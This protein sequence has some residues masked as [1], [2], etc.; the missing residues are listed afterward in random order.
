MS[1]ARATVA[2]L[3]ALTLLQALWGAWLAPLPGARW[4]ALKAVPL[5]ILVPGVARGQRRARQ[6]LALVTP[7]YFGEALVRAL[8]ESGR[9]GLVAAMAAALCV[10]TF[11]A[12]LA[13]LRDGK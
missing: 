7:L 12:V 2:G 8:T 5:A 6:W 11:V 4:L 1:A 9:H 3:V 10:V 13:W